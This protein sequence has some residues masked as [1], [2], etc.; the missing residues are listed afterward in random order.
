[1]KC[2][3]ELSSNMG[4]VE[5]IVTI[6][7][8]DQA[9]IDSNSSLSYVDLAFCKKH[10]LHVLPVH[11]GRSS[12]N[13]VTGETGESAIVVVTFA[14]EKCVRGLHQV[15][16]AMTTSYIHVYVLVAKS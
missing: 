9:T 6:N 14:N 5:L 12:S 13:E 1:M 15:V 10:N 2:T 3:N 16:H 7:G 11:T 4:G 8:G